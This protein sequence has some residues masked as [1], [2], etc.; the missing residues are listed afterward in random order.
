M[1]KRKFNLMGLAAFLLAMAPVM[2]ETRGSG[3]GFVGEPK[4]PAKYE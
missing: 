4:L 1:F 3:A 2:I